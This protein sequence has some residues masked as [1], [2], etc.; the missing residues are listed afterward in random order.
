[1]HP[2]SITKLFNLVF[3][4]YKKYETIFGIN[5]HT[6]FSP[7]NHPELQFSRY[8][9]L[10]ES[11][12]GVAAG[13]Q[14]QLSQNIIASWL[15]GSRYIELKTVQTL[16][17]LEVS[18]PCIDM[19]DE[20]YNCEWSQELKL[21][22]SFDEYLNAWVM[23]HILK[24]ELK[25]GDTAQSGMIFNMSVGYNL[26]GILNKNVQT[27]FEK[28]DNCKE[29]L[30]IVVE[31]LRPLYPNIDQVKIPFQITNN[32]TLSTMHGCPPD[33]IEKIGMYLLEKKNLHTTIK[34]NPTLNGAVALRDI[35]NNKLGFKDII[36]PDLAFDHDLKY[37][38]GIKLIKN[39]QKRADELNLDFGIK[40][41]NTLE[42]Q[43]NKNVFDKSNEM[44]YMSGRPLHALA[45][46][47]ALKIQKEFN[48]KLD[49]TFSAGVDA[50]NITDT[51][52]NRIKPVTVCTDL[53][54]PGGYERTKQYVIN[55]C[56][57]MKTLKASNLDELVTKRS[58]ES[59]LFKAAIINL[60]SYL[61]QILQNKRYHKSSFPWNNIKTK[62]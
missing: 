51:L 20:G 1:M 9:K 30:E 46:N 21:H 56:S 19:E 4:E 47:L 7:Q 27:F 52:A 24:H 54:K 22:Q 8:G 31:K 41:T 18:K 36:V 39:L 12:L 60:E 11:P 55:L 3:R 5:K 15:T 28:M 62:T 16:D 49:I 23:I 44:M 17:E 26:E 35:L 14:T 29:D 32:I 45:I 61:P 34:L 6:F 33:E 2:L 38:D 48:G 25:I 59:D 50:Y 43:N 42:T 37:D 10:L 53:L 57:E 40:L 58:K 13:P